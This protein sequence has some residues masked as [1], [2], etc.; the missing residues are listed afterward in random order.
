MILSGLLAEERY[1]RLTI[2]WRVILAQLTLIAL[3]LGV[4][5]Y[6][7]SQLHRLASLSS[8]IL[9]TDFARINAEKRLQQVF[10]I[11]KRS[12]EKYLVW[13]D[14]EFYN[15]FV[16]GS[17]DFTSALK[18]VAA[19]VNTPQ[20]RALLEQIQELYARYATGLSTAFTP[21]S[22]WNQEKNEI[23]EKIATKI[24]EL[25]RFREEMITRKT[26]TARDQAVSAASTVGWLS[27][28]GIIAAIFFAYVH[29]RGVSRPL[30]KLTQ[31]LLRVGQGEFHGVLDVRAPKEVGELVQTFNWMAT[32]LE[33]LDRM[34]ADFIAHISHELRTPLTGIQ[35]G[36]ALLIEQI[37]GPLTTAQQQILG[38][39]RHYGTQLARH[40]TAILDLSKMEAGM[41][42]Y[43][44]VQSN[45]AVLL[46]RSVEAVQLMAQKK[47]LHL[48]VLCTSPLPD[49][50]LDEG[51]MQEVLD[52]LLSNA[53]K[54]TPEG[55]TIRMAASLQGEGQSWVEIRVCDTG[56]GIPA[57]DVPRIFDKFYQS[58]YHRQERQQGTGL[59]L[60]IARHIVEAH[61]GKIWAESRV[62]EGATFVVT[63]PVS[64]SEANLVLA[65][66]TIQHN[67][68]RH[69]A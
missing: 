31:G 24:E 68:V 41:L 20:E 29:A 39:V 50:C 34:K 8:D 12:A 33:E 37:P 45:P 28:G 60:T 36:T 11:Q 32:R 52:N 3:I 17:S 1:V 40:I 38:V 65:S 16:E 69:V 51:R 62:G 9:A 47:R 21:K 57:E 7:L 58:S 53:V 15:H 44:R 63:L 49:L 23:S 54:F 13:R 67:G 18:K 59:G 55:G 30:K 25:I 43:V 66:P 64:H 35:E 56:K 2:F 27:L 48:E 19:L 10:R 61:G 26:V 42:E 22:A 14:N 6:A 4:S 46:E 5:L